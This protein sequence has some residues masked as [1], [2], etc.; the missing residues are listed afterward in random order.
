MTAVAIPLYVQLQYGTLTADFL[1]KNKTE[2]LTM[3]RRQRLRNPLT[4][5]AME[6]KTAGGATH[7]KL[8]QC[9]RIVMHVCPELLQI[10]DVVGMTVVHDAARWCWDEKMLELIM[11]HDMADIN[12]KDK[13][14]YRPLHYAA[15]IG[16]IPA[17]T[18]LIKLGAD[19]EAQTDGLSDRYTPL[20]FALQYPAAVSLLLGAKASATWTGKYGLTLLH[21]VPE[22]VRDEDDA[23]ET[24]RMLLM[25]GANLTT[26]DYE[27]KTP[28]DRAASMNR[29]KLLAWL[30][31]AELRPIAPSN[32]WRPSSHWLCC[33]EVRDAVYGSL[34]AAKRIRS[35]PLELWFCIFELLPVF[36]H[37]EAA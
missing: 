13:V 26:R 31:R 2:I 27:K 12:G 29:K 30:R 28:A 36:L 1:Q 35:L 33:R 8:L 23:I 34:L 4:H 14:D 3:A 18:Q 11:S 21:C 37:A 20:Y 19:L 15:G 5:L 25:A 10:P 17:M 24:S 7:S 22:D 16:N 32:K 9:A 6:T